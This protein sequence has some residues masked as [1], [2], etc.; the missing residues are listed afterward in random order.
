M[1]INVTCVTVTVTE[2]VH[3][4]CRKKTENIHKSLRLSISLSVINIYCRFNEEQ[5]QANILN[6]SE[7]N[8]TVMLPTITLLKATKMVKIAC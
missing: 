1:H 2:K 5:Q 7:E 3:L 6:D 4:K 8:A